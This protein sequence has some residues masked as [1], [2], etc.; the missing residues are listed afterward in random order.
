MAKPHAG[1]ARPR[2]S[3]TLI[4]SALE[5]IGVLYTIS[6]DVRDFREMGETRS[7]P[8]RPGCSR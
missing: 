6:D 4:G 8:R 3:G 7:K 2:D 5:A 1:A